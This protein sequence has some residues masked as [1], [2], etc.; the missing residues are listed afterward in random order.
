M[1]CDACGARMKSGRENFLY[2]AC[3]LDTVTLMNVEVHRCGEC[4]EYEVDI[5]RIEQ[6]HR[7]IAQEVADKEARLTPAEIRFLRK[8]LGF[9]G[10][11]FAAVLDVTP[12]TVSRWENGKKQMSPVSERALRLMVF[13][14]APITEYPLERLARVAQG[15]A[16]PLRMKLRESR[17]QWQAEHQAA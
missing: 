15:E 17:A 11:D 12:E 5:P 14:R 10:V 9:S 6:L 8:Y 4:G 2:T 1:T 7:L 13:V 3:G 16:L